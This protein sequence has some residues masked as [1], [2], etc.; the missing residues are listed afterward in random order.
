MQLSKN[1]IVVVCISM[2]LTLLSGLAF[3]RTNSDCGN[4]PVEQGYLLDHLVYS[5]GNVDYASFCIGGNG[6][7]TSLGWPLP[8]YVRSSGGTVP[9]PQ[10][11]AY[12]HVP[13]IL[14]NIVILSTIQLVAL[15]VLRRP[16]K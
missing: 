6:T 8:V 15:H 11:T 1:I 3:K 7:D 13:F 16:A 5:K 2:A 14:L 4:V 12:P 9:N 10:S